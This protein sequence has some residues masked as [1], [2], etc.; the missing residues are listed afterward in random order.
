MTHLSRGQIYNAFLGRDARPKE[1]GGKEGRTGAFRH[2]VIVS[3]SVI[4]KNSDRVTIAPVMNYKLDGKELHINWGF[5]LP[6]RDVEDARLNDHNFVE[7]GQLWTV[8]SPHTSEAAKNKLPRDINLNNYRGTLRY[9]ER[10]DLA[11]QI[12]I[13]DRIIISKETRNSKI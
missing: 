5:W 10:L 3:S 8:F 6:N 2:V 12:A 9:R 13:N 7:C 4:N 11:L 1:L